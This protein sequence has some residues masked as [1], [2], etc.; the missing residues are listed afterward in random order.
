MTI[1]ILIF[2]YLLMQGLQPRL[3]STGQWDQVQ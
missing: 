3:R 1:V 2:I